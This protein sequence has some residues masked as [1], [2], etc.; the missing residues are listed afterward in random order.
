MLL[1][2]QCCN[3]YQQF[4]IIDII[5]SFCLI[6]AFWIIGVWVP[7]S[8]FNFLDLKNCISSNSWGI[9]VNSY[10]L[11]R[12]WMCQYWFFWEFLFEMIKSFLASRGSWSFNIL[13]SKFYQR[14]GNFDKAQE[15]SDSFY[16]LWFL[17]L[18]ITAM[19]E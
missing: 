4:F 18:K 11:T 16:Y 15:T 10:W 6:K 2:I 13:L 9:T 8:I 5:I 12:I 17:L 14:L 19:R 3:D 7:I 1:F